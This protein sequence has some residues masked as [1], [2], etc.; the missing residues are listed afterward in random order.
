MNTW[1]AWSTPRTRGSRRFAGR[2]WTGA[3]AWTRCTLAGTERSGVR[4][5]GRARSWRRRRVTAEVCTFAVRG[6]GAN[7][8]TMNNCCRSVAGEEQAGAPVPTDRGEPLPEGVP[9]RAREARAPHRALPAFICDSKDSPR[10]YRDRRG[11][12]EHSSGSCCSRRSRT[13]GYQKPTD[14]KG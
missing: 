9:V 8:P 11:Q 6:S 13:G 14:G 1:G 2:I 7:S 5:G 3:S 10:S 12:I 4:L